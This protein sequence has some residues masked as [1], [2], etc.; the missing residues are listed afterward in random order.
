MKPLTHAKNSVRRFGG[1]VEDYL[2]IHN[3]MD[4]TK[5]YIPD[6]RHRMILHN[7]WGIMMGE[8]VLGVYFTNS[9]GKDISVRDVLEQHVMEDLGH[10][11]TLEKCM[12]SLVAEP[13]MGSHEISGRTIRV[14]TKMHNVEIV[15]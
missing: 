7:A 6:M 1:R 13:W 14:S 12:N 2:R 9:E 10:I 5:G 8:Q 11:P 3:W 15:D 4:S